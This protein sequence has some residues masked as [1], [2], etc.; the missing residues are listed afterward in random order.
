MSVILLGLGR[1]VEEIVE[2]VS[3]ISD[4]VLVERDEARL[5]AFLEKAPVANLRALPGSAT[6]VG[7]WKEVDLEAAEAVISFLSVEATLD[8]ARLLRK[9]LGYRGKIVHVSKARPDPQAVRELDLEVVSIPEVLGAILRNL[10]QG[11]GIVRYPV[12]IGLRKGEV[13]EVLITESSPAVYARLRELRQ[14]GAR[15][16]LVYREGSPILPRADFR[17]QPGDRLLVVGDP[18]G[19]EI[20]VGAVIRGEPTFPR[21]FGSVGALCRAEDEEALYLKERLKVRDWVEACE[22]PK[23]VAEVGVFL[24]RDRDWVRRA[25]Q[26]GYP[27]PS[28]HLRG[29]HPYRSILVSAN[30]EALSPLLASAMDLARIFGSEVYVL[31]VSRVE[32]F[33]PPEEKELLENLKLLV[34]RARKTSGL[35]VH[36]IRKEGNPVRETLKLL[37]GKFNLLALG[38]TPGR[39]TAFFRPY[40]PQLLAQASPVSTLLVPEVNLER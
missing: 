20:F 37:K 16:A 17:I 33:M 2:V 21:R 36:L 24:A 38:Y 4:V 10:L 1:Y 35:E 28:F 3:A 12:G 39:R 18:R 27:F 23:G 22:D 40:V 9:A 15:V 7:L 26:E 32:A 31:F 19:V 30:T 8:V 5:R 13:V 6:D 11:Q 14:P 25:F 34:E 29:T